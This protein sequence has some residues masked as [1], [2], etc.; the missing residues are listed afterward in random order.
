MPASRKPRKSKGKAPYQGMSA[1]AY[2][3]LHRDKMSEEKRLETL[4]DYFAAI[5]ALL[6]GRAGYAHW[7]KLVYAANV[8]RVLADM[9]I[10]DQYGDMIEQG[11]IAVQKIKE[12]FDTTGKWG[13]DGDGRRAL[14]EMEDLHRAQLEAATEGEIAAA[15]QGMWRRIN[16]GNRFKLPAAA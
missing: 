8:T 12:R 3:M 13:I 1:L 11:M 6:E 4:T 2:R 15:I 16:T 10:G 5:N 14:S 9:G 7:E